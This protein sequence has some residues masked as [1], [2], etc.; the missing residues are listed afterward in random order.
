M[1]EPS[2]NL[3]VTNLPSGLDESMVMQFFSIYGTVTTC[4]VLTN[5]IFTGRTA[6][7]VRFASVEEA[8]SILQTL[9]GSVPTGLDEPVQV[10]F[11]AKKD[12]TK[13]GGAAGMGATGAQKGGYG[14]WAGGVIPPTNAVSPYG[15][16]AA[17]KGGT[18]GSWGEPEISD[19]IYVQGLPAGTTE[20][21]LQQT[22]MEFGNIKSIKLLPS[23]GPDAP[24]AALIRYDSSETAKLTKEI[25]NGQT[26][27]GFP[28]PLVVRYANQP[29]SQMASPAASMAAGMAAGKG[30]WQAQQQAQQQAASSWKGQTKGGMEGGILCA[31]LVDMVYQSDMLPGGRKYNNPRASLYVAGL[32]SDATEV[33]LYKMFSP[34]GAIHSCITRVGGSPDYSWVIGFVNYLDPLSAEAAITAYNGMSLPDGNQ[35]KVTIKNVKNQ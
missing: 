20:E 34:Y 31:A 29:G 16:P 22:F 9:N 12:P 23:K 1:G 21:S 25:L 13:G 28:S 4:K 7:L 27:E 10:K 32:P 17:A 15:N 18:P 26:P 19:N 33:H 35:L 2:D 14:Q 30:V 5:P 8:T 3:Y 11:A 24:C 6:A